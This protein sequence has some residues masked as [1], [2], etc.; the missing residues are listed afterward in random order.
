MKRF[1]IALVTIVAL[2]G[3]ALP[4]P[5]SLEA[6]KRAELEEIRRQAREKREA[7]SRLKGQENQ[8]LGQLKRTERQL[9][10]TRKRLRQLGHR[11][12]SL[13]VQLENT[14]SDL[15]RNVLALGDRRE[16]LRRRLRALYKFGPAREL[17]FLF[18]TESFAQLLTRWDFLLMVAEQDRQ[19]LE[20]VRDRKE[21]V[22]TLQHRLEGHLTEV[23]RTARQTTAETRRLAVQH[24]ARRGAVTEIQTQRQ[25]YEAAAA[26]LE[27]T[28]RAIQGL[29][30]RLERKRREETEKA[31][32]EGRSIMPYSGNFARGQG[33]LDWPVRGEVVGR[34]GPEH[35]P[36]F[37]VVTPNNG[38]DISAPIGSPVRAVGK[39]RVDYTAEDYGTYGQ[40]VILNHGDSYYT[41]YGHLSEIS[42]SV[43]QEVS[44]GQIIGRSG[45]TGSLKGPVLHFE[46]RR[47]GT[48]LNPEDWLQ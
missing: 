39:G 35:H 36:R 42:V 34:F 28:A 13:D 33:A 9:N 14:R 24:A 8:A 31:R 6:V 18:S 22:E 25:A 38:I 15:E 10:L 4:E 44:A 32:A 20:D 43:G 26:E 45:D 5:D 46:V 7:A 40:I 16:K 17:E 47:G 41:L 21:V 29:L 1:A 30:A 3:P 11:R 37:N 48:A 2:A 19:L 27:K 23:N 12:R